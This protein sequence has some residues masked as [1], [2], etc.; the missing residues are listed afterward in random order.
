MKILFAA[1]DRDLLRAYKEIL[2]EDFGETQT[3][4]DGPQMLTLLA[5]GNYDLAVLDKGLPRIEN[6]LL[7]DHLNSEGIP[8]LSLLD[9]REK[10]EAKD[11]FNAICYPFTPA[12]LEESIKQ[13]T[14]RIDDT[15]AQGSKAVTENE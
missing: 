7:I 9:F 1:P 8:V 5:E 10:K 11:R 14:T 15:L 2:T 4:F 6:K 12:E 3:A 13:M